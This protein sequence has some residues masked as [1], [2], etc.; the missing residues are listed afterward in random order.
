MVE[1]AAL[2]AEEKCAQL[3]SNHAQSMEVLRGENAQ[4]RDTAN[5]LRTDLDA[6]RL[7]LEAASQTNQELRDKIEILEKQ[8]AEVQEV[9]SVC[10]I[11]CL[12]F[13]LS[14]M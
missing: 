4:E 2:N 6:L 1:Q 12:T 14:I 8:L 9:R 3:E 13:I 7:R 5:T 11:C 10:R